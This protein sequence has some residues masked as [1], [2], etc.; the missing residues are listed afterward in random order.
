MNGRDTENH[1]W[2]Y[3]FLVFDDDNNNKHDNDVDR[4]KGR[5]GKHR[6]L[7]IQTVSYTFNCFVL[8]LDI[9]AEIST[10]ITC[11]S[12]STKTFNFLFSFYSFLAFSS[13]LLLFFFSKNSIIECCCKLFSANKFNECINHSVK[14]NID[15]DP[16]KTTNTRLHWHHIKIVVD[17]HARIKASEIWK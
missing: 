1:C 8:C 10:E 13:S 6:I 4:K 9:E 15:V 3:V 11:A 14:F 16:Q 12:F 7:F 17:A 2:I 5:Q